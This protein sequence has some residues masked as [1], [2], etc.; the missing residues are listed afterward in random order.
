VTAVGRNHPFDEV[1]A[2]AQERI[3]AGD[4]V[5]QKYDCQRCGKRLTM[6]VPNVFFHTGQCEVCGHVTDIRSAGCNY[7]LIRSTRSII[8]PNSPGQARPNLN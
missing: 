5:F 4:T 3:R 8:T 2:G 7:L 6:D 1:V